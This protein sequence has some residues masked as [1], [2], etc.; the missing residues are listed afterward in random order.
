M[1]EKQYDGTVERLRSPD[2]VA[3]LEVGRVAS[4]CL[5]AGDYMTALDVGV[6]SGLFAE[7]FSQ[8]G[9]KV[10]GVDVNPQM[11]PAAR[12]YVPG[13]D[14]REATAE[15]L[16]YPDASFDLVFM[17]L[18]LHE[19]DEPLEALQEARR[20]SRQRVCVLEWPYREDETFGP[21]LAHRL[22]PDKVE[23]LVKRAGFSR[24]ETI[25][26]EHLVLYRLTI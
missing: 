2:R 17:G 15:A 6:G 18:V 16:P 12:Q 14:F 4:L 25:P 26:L 3:R 10:A 19:S 21:P 8:H 5:E 9:L 13:G 11:L 24:L 20:A 23:N 7:A 22:S 1:H